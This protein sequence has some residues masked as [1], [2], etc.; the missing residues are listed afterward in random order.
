MGFLKIDKS[1]KFTKK[2]ALSLLATTALYR[3]YL[4]LVKSLKNQRI[5]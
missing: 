5:I 3:Y 1:H 2:K 4:C